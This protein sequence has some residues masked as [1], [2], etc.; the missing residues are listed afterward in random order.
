MLAT[1]IPQF[2][3][4]QL[5][6]ADEKGRPH[7]KVRFTHWRG[8]G[9]WQDETQFSD[10]TLRLIGFLWTLQEKGAPILF[11]EPELS[12]HPSLLRQMAPFIHKA[13][14]A[15]GDRQVLLSTHSEHILEDEGI[16]PEEIL[17]VRPANEGSEILSGDQIPEIL[18]DMRDGMSAASAVIPR[19]EAPRV[20]DW[21]KTAVL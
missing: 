2:E 8:Q 15:G 6:E 7:L 20:K 4:L 17:V 16:A 9:A 5:E 19:A 14:K 18:E 21:I 11:E 1:A 13:R 10:G 3:E 12:L